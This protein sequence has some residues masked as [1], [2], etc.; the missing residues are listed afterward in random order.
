MMDEDAISN[1][2]VRVKL[3]LTV[4]DFVLPATPSLPAVFGVSLSS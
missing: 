2:T 3:N 4:W 1:L